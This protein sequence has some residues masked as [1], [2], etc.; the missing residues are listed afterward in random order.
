LDTAFGDHDPLGLPSGVKAMSSSSHDG[1]PISATGGG[2]RHFSMSRDKFQIDIPE[3]HLTLITNGNGDGHLNGGNLPSP[4]PLRS[5]ND[6]RAAGF[7]HEGALESAQKARNLSQSSGDQE[8]ATN[9]IQNKQHS[10]DGTNPLK[11]RSA[12]AGLDYPRRRATIAVRKSS[13][14]LHFSS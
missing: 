9:G 4:S 5:P 14:A 6:R 13:L 2:S 1:S 10:D 3:K 11:R 8:Y 12:D 7:S